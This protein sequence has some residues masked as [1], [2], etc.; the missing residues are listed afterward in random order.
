MWE[1]F[2]KASPAAFRAIWHYIYTDD[3]V[4]V[5]ELAAPEFVATKARA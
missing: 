5:A 4:R 1:S 2:L 3:P